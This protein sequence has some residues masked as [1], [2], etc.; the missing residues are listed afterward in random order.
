MP[1]RSSPAPP[2]P[3]SAEAVLE[4]WLARLPRTPQALGHGAR[5]SSR[6]SRSVVR[7]PTRSGIEA[8]WILWPPGSGVPLH[9]HTG[10]SRVGILHGT[11]SEVVH[12]PGGGIRALR[13]WTDERVIEIAPGQQHEVRNLSNSTAAS[14]HIYEPARANLTFHHPSEAKP[15]ARQRPPHSP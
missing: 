7:L 11:L 2:E 6:P 14:V 8:T 5:A 1:H 15:R 10:A 13:N 4:Y 12:G 3:T 9:D